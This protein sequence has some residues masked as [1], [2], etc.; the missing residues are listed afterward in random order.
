VARVTFITPMPKF[1]FLAFIL[2]LTFLFLFSTGCSSRAS[3]AQSLFD[4]G[5]YQKVIQRYPDLEIARR[6]HAKL[7]EQLLQK[8]DYAAIMRDYSDTPSAYKAKL[9]MAQ[10]LF[11]AGKYQALLDSFPL[12]PLAVAAKGKMA[13]SL[14]AAGQSDKVVLWYPDTP[15]AKQIK[16][17]QAQTEIARI[18]KLPKKDKT[19][20]LEEFMKK[21]A[22]SAAS[23]EANDM[24]G[25]IREAEN[26]QALKKK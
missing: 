8:K 19:K 9:D 6:A 23:Q 15:Q 4:K 24:L 2:P 7:A 5:E 10:R 22:G 14:I 20:A 21:F 3:S 25:K 1:R 11:D 18:K 16:D 12:S 26:K 17:E 13:D